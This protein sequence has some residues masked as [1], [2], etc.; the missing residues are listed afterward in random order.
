MLFRKY[1]FYSNS[2]STVATISS[3]IISKIIP[4]CFRCSNNFNLSQGS[5]GFYDKNIV[6]VSE[7]LT[8]GDLSNFLR[9]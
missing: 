3:L 6:E 1:A 2:L 5:L 9:D 8:S 4:A 7:G